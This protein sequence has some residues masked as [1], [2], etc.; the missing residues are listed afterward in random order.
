M[1]R[2]CSRCATAI[3]AHLTVITLFAPASARAD[4]PFVGVNAGAPISGETILFTDALAVD[5]KDD[6][7]FEVSLADVRRVVDALRPH[8]VAGAR[9][10]AGRPKATCSPRRSKATRARRPSPAC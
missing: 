1:V 10:R 8:R 3:V 5:M 4:V 6:D 9:R 2:G 7:A